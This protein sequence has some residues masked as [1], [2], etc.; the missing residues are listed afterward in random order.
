MQENSHQ[1]AP[2]PEYS[3]I[4]ACYNEERSIR[5]FHAALSPVMRALGRPYEVVIVNDGSA[6][7]TQRVLEEIFAAD[8]AVAAVIEFCRN[9]GQAAAHTAGIVEAR[10]KTLIFIDSDLQIDPADLPRLLEAF[11]GGL[12]LVNARRVGRKDSAARRIASLAANRMVRSLTGL[13]LTDLYSGFKVA[14]ADIVK[15][16]DWGPRRVFFSLDAMRQCARCAEVEVSHRPR[17]YGRS[18]W[19]AARLARLLA[20]S[21][22]NFMDAPFR[23]TVLPLLACPVLAAAAFPLGLS[24]T[25]WKGTA[26]VLAWCA[27]AAA[28][29][30]GAYA[31][32]L[33]RASRGMP[34]Y[35]VRRALRR[36]ADGAQ[37]TEP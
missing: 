17:T 6:D 4:L 32:R 19:G 29:L 13:P 37:E 12:D 23:W 9:S 30:A 14:R 28:G 2:P 24:G 3:V 21:V 1:N 16:F 35:V 34:A 15:A 25:A 33:H 8:P 22:L 31:Q 7:G 18:G 36:R 20:D 11:D 10:G 26:W 27:L 5:E